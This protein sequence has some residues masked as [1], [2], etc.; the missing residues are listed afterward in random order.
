[1]YGHIHVILKDMIISLGGDGA[2]KK[3]LAEAGRSAPGE[4]DKVCDPV[5]Q[6]DEV[7]MRLVRATCKVLGVSV[8][9]AL[10]AFGKHFVVFTLRTGLA[11]FFKSQGATLPEF[12]ENVNHMHACFERDH[13]GARFPSVKSKYDAQSD[14]ALVTYVS[15]RTGLASLLIGV[16]EELGRR[17]Y[18][19][20]VRFDVVEVP[21][22]LAEAAR[23]GRASAWHVTWKK[24]RSGVGALEGLDG[25]ESSQVKSGAAAACSFFSLHCGLVSIL[26]QADLLTT[27]RQGEPRK[28]SGKSSLPQCDSSSSWEDDYEDADDVLS[29]CSTALAN[30]SSSDSSEQHPI[31]IQGGS[32]L[33]KKNQVEM[34]G[35]PLDRILLRAARAEKVA[36]TWLDSQ[37]KG[38]RSFWE[39]SEGSAQDY[40]LSEDA[41]RVDIFVS[42]CWRAPEEW[43][44]IFGEEASYADVKSSTLAT[45]AK[46]L[47][48][49]KGG[50]S[51]WKAMTVW[52]D[53]AC[54]PQ[55]Q[56]ALKESCIN[57][58]E[59]FINHC[60]NVCL[61]FTWSYLERLWCVY[62][63]ACV[64]ET[65]EARK[66][67][68]ANEQFV[69]EQTLPL[70]INAV[71]RFSLKSTKCC[72]ESDRTILQ[73]KIEDT[74]VSHEAFEE[75]VKAAAAAFMARSMAF[76]AGRSPELRDRFFTPWVALAAEL[77]LGEL[78]AALAACKAHSWREAAKEQLG[79]SASKYH[80]RINAWFDET[81]D[82]VLRRLRLSAVL[83][84]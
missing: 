11:A 18:D 50:L 63:L 54:I 39:S 45:M 10:H 49:S 35:R 6:E 59:R 4:E 23:Q 51:A 14:S 82:P 36:G 69:T 75:L 38:I 22:G 74:Y 70:Y 76:R 62:E 58:L 44:G 60:E 67:W 20:D 40:D 83:H 3:V 53:K 26:R 72:M 42:H 17:L 84:N 21:A 66:V 41:S 28:A 43:K 25:L 46:E 37:S 77:Q 64:L 33:A 61:L 7:T 8:E 16:V 30:T 65:K 5:A 13:P 79:L 47:A 73:K 55:D 71:R 9:T 57:L 29:Q 48:L 81:V 56:A 78:A 31:R 1:M 15:T 12:L 68:M 19:V 32:S 34:G 2:W 27:C 52:V 80:E 24:R